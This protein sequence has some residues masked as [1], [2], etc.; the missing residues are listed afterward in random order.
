MKFFPPP[1]GE[2]RNHRPKRRGRKG[3][4]EGKGGKRERKG[5]IEGEND[6]KRRRVTAEKRDGRGKRM[7]WIGRDGEGWAERRRLRGKEEYKELRKGR[8]R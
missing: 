6:R 8:G 1:P 5:K 2:E 4:S 7:K 3:K